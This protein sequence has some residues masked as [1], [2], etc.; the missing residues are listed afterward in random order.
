ME[1]FYFCYKDVLNGG[2][3]KWSF[4]SAYFILVLL[5]FA[6]WQLSS[7]FILLTA[8]YGG[9]SLIIWIVQPYKKRYMTVLE[10]LIAAN[11]ALI[12]ALHI[13]IADLFASSFHLAMLVLSNTLPLLELATYL[14]FQLLKKLR[15][16]FFF[17]KS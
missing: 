1:K 15:S 8:L 17:T 14:C 10:S 13:D 7:R 6:A 2:R 16:S 12:A 11:L 3:D 9:Y 4:A 5:S